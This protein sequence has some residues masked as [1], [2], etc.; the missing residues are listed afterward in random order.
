MSK[1][2]ALSQKLTELGIVWQEYQ[3]EALETCNDAAALGLERDGRQLKN[4]FLRD[5]YGRVHILLLT[6][7]EVKVDLNALSKAQGLSRLGFASSERF[8]RYLGVNPGCVSGLALFNDTE[9]AVELWLDEGLLDEARWQCHPFDNCY[10]WVLTQKDLRLF[11]QHLG[12]QPK[13]ISLP[14]KE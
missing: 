9:R 13:S 3:H 4:L 12:Y 8:N 1:R 2:E 7:A 14:L 6:R 11:W 5:N 10:T